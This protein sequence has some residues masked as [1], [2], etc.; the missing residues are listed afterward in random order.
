V[1]Q[2]VSSALQ[3]NV[4]EKIGFVMGKMTA[5]TAEMNEI[6]SDRR[7]ILVLRPNSSVRAKHSVCQ[8]TCSVTEKLTAK[9]PAMKNSAVSRKKILSRYTYR[10]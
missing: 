2:T 7:T 6:V 5:W 4:S 8:N 9:M 1:N 10:G 3:V